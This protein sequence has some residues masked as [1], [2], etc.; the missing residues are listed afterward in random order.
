MLSHLTMQTKM[1][2]EIQVLTNS[3]TMTVA[4]E[5][6][7]VAAESQSQ[8]NAKRKVDELFGDID[9]IDFDEDVLPKR[10]KTFHALQQIEELSEEQRMDITIQ[11]IL[12]ARRQFE[13]ETNVEMPKHSVE[14]ARKSIAARLAKEIS[15]KVPTFPFIS[16]T[17]RV[18]ERFYL[19]FRSE[20]IF[21]IEIEEAMR[22][23]GGG[24]LLNVPFSKLKEDAT[25]ILQKSYDL[26]EKT[27]META[28]DTNLDAEQSVEKELWV[29]KYRPRRYLDLL[30]DEGTNKSLLKWLKLWDK[31]VFNRENKIIAKQKFEKFEDKGKAG[32]GKFKKKFETELRSE[33][34]ELGR[35][36]HKVALLC[37]PPGLGKT[38]LAH[39]LARHAGYNVVEM[40]ASDDRSPELF[41]TQLEAATQM[42][43]VMGK[44]PRPNCLILDEIDG[45]PQAS[46][47]VV[48]RFAGS[49]EGAEKGAKKKKKSEAVVLRRPVICICNDAYVP[50]LRPLRQIAYV[51]H[52]PP[53]CSYRLAQ[54]LC[55]VARLQR[56]KTDVG[57]MLALGEK[58][59][60]DIRACLA[61][62][63]CLK[64]QV[65]A[66][67]R[68]AHVNNAHIGTKD[69]QKSLF[70]VWQEVFQVK[71]NKNRFQSILQTVQGY[72]DYD[73]LAQGV[74]ENFL[75]MKMTGSTLKTVCESL[76]WFMH[77][78]TISSHIQSTQNYALYSHMA[79]PFVKW[80]FLFARRNW[81]KLLYPS[82]GYEMTTRLTKTNGLLEEML[83]GMSPL[84]RPFMRKQTLLL[85]VV[86]LLLEIII[87]NLRPVSFTLYSHKEK[88]ELYKV[89]NAMIDY[90]LSYT[91]ER[92]PDGNYAFN[93]DPNIE[94]VAKFPGWKPL[95][96]M[97]YGLK[98]QVQREINLERMRRLDIS[99]GQGK[100]T[101]KKAAAVQKQ[102][103]KRNAE[104]SVPN[105]LQRLTPKAMKKPETVSK[106]F[107]GRII[108]KEASAQSGCAFEE[109]KDIWLRFKEGYNNA[110]RLK[111][112]MA[113]LF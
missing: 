64:V 85:D 74:Y 68:L 111:V 107:F 59:N 19:R 43:A 77:Y 53:T 106:D 112:S 4:D 109:G 36:H 103:E 9:D 7:P 113:D 37:G 76:Q 13:I 110:V 26:N 1:T 25:N 39:I 104:V 28:P 16:A 6:E 33:L 102:P 69:V 105:H 44:D 30:S 11:K 61:L 21:D 2:L 46:I 42:K 27:E 35:P 95:R 14:D 56:L 24:G 20:D 86:S 93:L 18:G 84:T 87:P 57:T 51:L 55:E 32:G 31:V 83:R 90:N 48:V 49:K 29:E 17:G 23:C 70:A 66:S 67:I 65:G 82:M 52:F 81:V 92:T 8:T 10:A 91:Q 22:R 38:T 94:D 78:D 40:N 71:T 101:E 62:M 75:A 15:R 47:E 88:S 34:D 12:F 5:S 99:C 100:P 54:R 63:H 73:R 98:Q 79:F 80:H 45:A 97:G 60:N 41:R 3:F 50:A 108:E 58:T 89:V 72:G 96:T